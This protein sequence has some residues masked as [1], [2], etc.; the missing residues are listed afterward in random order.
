MDMDTDALRWLQQVADGTTLTEVS[1]VEPVTQSGVSRAL[2]RLE[3]QIGT[4][5]LRDFHPSLCAANL[6]A[7][8]IE[9]RGVQ[10]HL[11]LERERRHPGGNRF[12]HSHARAVAKPGSDQCHRSQSVHAR[13]SANGWCATANHHQ[14]GFNQSCFCNFREQPCFRYWLCRQRCSGE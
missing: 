4:P 10:L 14:P 5:L 12:P 1:E 8:G 9:A 6:A 2:A 3:E 11:E 7:A 13:I